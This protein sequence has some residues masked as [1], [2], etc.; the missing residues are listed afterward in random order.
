MAA[1]KDIPLP[2]N[3]ETHN[4]RRG[5][6]SKIN[7]WFLYQAALSVHLIIVQAGHIPSKTWAILEQN[8]MLNNLNQIWA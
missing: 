3:V 1:Q 8:S 4:E 5:I 2:K 7:Q 6:L